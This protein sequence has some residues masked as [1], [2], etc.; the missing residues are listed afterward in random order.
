MKQKL[1]TLLLAVV[2]SVGTMF[3]DSTKIGD[4]YYALNDHD[5]P[6]TGQAAS[7]VPFTQEYMSL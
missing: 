5:K 3:I 7:S 6:A 1:F 2:A 4:L